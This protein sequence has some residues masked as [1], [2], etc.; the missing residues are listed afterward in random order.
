MI[1]DAQFKTEDAASYDAVAEVFD[2]LTRRYAARS[3]D[4]LARAI[5]APQRRCILDIGCGT[6]LVAF[7]AAEL[8][9]PQTRIIGI[10]L[11]EGMLRSAT[12]AARTAGLTG[13]VSFQSGDAEALELPDGF[14]D[15]Y[16]SLNAWSHLPHPDRAAAEAFRVLSPGG[17]IA[18]AVGSGPQLLSVAGAGRAVQAVL[19]GVRIR[20]GRE[21]SAC[22]HLEQLVLRHLHAVPDPETSA[23]AGAGRDFSG[24]LR[25]LLRRAGFAG[26][27]Q[28][29][30]GADFTIPTVEE[31]WHLQ[32]TLST[33]ARKRMALADGAALAALKAAFWADCTA[34][35]NRGG[36]LTYKVGAAIVTGRRPG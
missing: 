13:R 5:D 6:G 1:R 20:L 11:S 8:S 29:W 26:V 33:P 3:A 31:F 24:I 14:A 18:V 25:D 19:C 23:L 22:T 21:R 9:G 7:K 17:R 15:G 12:A 2:G 32:T 36:K 10:D 28:R 35:L 30:T 16:V 34:V 4:T 27:Q